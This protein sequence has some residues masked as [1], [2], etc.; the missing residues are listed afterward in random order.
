MLEAL[1]ITCATSSLTAEQSTEPATPTACY[2]RDHPCR[3]R[4]L[5]Q[6]LILEIGAVSKVGDALVR[7]MTALQER[8]QQPCVMGQRPVLHRTFGGRLQLASYLSPV[9]RRRRRAAFRRCLVCGVRADSSTH[10]PRS[11]ILLSPS[12]RR[13]S[14]S[15]LLYS[16]SAAVG[17]RN[18]VEAATY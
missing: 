16:G 4:P 9:S 15:C 17:W 13:P 6:L 7:R 1:V 14:L 18:A 2:W 12:G 10:S 5:P 8:I 3:R 11:A